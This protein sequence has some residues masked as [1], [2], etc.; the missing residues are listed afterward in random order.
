MPNI[1]LLPWRAEQRQRRQR[2]FL[3]GLGVAVVFAALVALLARLWVAG[4]IDDQVARN[5]LLRSEIA[6]LDKQIEEILKLEEEKARLVSRMEIIETLQKSRPE[7]VQLFDEIVK[8]LPDG[9]YLAKVSQS[10]HKLEFSG[11]AQSSTRVSAFMRNI[12]SSEILASPGLRV[13]ETGRGQGA[14][15]SLSAA[16]RASAGKEDGQ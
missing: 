11:T 9:V 10:G 4:L 13:I 3:A 6:V 1:N 12:D 2:D 16:L 15:F 5:D 14:S 7:V 8:T